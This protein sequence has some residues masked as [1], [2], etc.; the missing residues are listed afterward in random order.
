MAPMRRWELFTF[1]E[2]ISREEVERLGWFNVVPQRPHIT[3]SACQN[4]ESAYESDGQGVFTRNIIKVLNNSRG[5]VTYRGLQAKVR[6]Y[7]RNQ[8]NQTP[9]VYSTR[10]NTE[11]LLR[12][13]IDRTGEKG[14]FFILCFHKK[15]RG[16]AIDLG[17]AQGV[18][19]N[20]GPVRIKV[21]DQTI[22]AGI[23]EIKS[24]YTLLTIPDEVL[25]KMEES[26]QYEAELE[27]YLS[28]SV[29]FTIDPS[30][31]M[32]TANLLRARVEE[33][34]AEGRL[35]FSLT[36]T[37]SEA[38]YEIASGNGCL[39][40]RHSA[41]HRYPVFTVKEDELAFDRLMDAMRHI[42]KW[43]FVRTYENP[44]AD[45]SSG[46]PVDVRFELR[47]SDGQRKPLE[48]SRE[49]VNL[50]FQEGATLR[51]SVE[52]KSDTKYYCSL[53]YLSNTFQVLGSL[54][55]NKVTGLNKEETALVFN[56]QELPLILENHV[57][58][59]NMP[60]SVSYLKLIANTEEFRVESL[61][62]DELPAPKRSCTDLGDDAGGH[63]GLG[64]PRKEKVEPIPWFTRTIALKIS[65]PEYTEV[66]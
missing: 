29:C 11:D 61:E 37:G 38:S 39:S 1:G 26:E 9:E 64:V 13:F 4:D 57:R 22:E 40:I 27:N 15:D 53:L 21:G 5:A 45:L 54:L 66:N 36:E 43:E 8:F 44:D 24:D 28:G 62:M 16:W 10:H 56:G 12:S 18:R 60:E 52:N 35:P 6:Q 34:L 55:D 58:E 48:Y 7:I 23:A 20:S 30:L 47:S 51:I 65:N 32:T 3:M 46:F 19:L 17:S 14:K 33:S 2:V 49:T 41:G 42:A 59:F 25:A 63:R 31:D 50:D